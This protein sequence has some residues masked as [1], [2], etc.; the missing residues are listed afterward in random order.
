MSIACIVAETNADV[1]LQ[2]LQ[3]SQISKQRNELVEMSLAWGATHLY[4]QDS[5]I[6]APASTANELLAHNKDIV[7]AAYMRKR[8]PYIMLGTL[9]R[10]DGRLKPATRMPGGCML[11]KADVYRKIGW[12]WYFERILDVETRRMQGEDYSFCEKAIEG[13][14][15]IW[16]DIDLTQRLQHLGTQAAQI[17]FPHDHPDKIV[18]QA[19][20]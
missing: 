8:P 17:E 13:G 9:S 16:C 4:W 2:C 20:S 14:F 5:D 18:T 6:V 11:V 19:S 12:P 3:G 1:S 15:D 10:A 7:G